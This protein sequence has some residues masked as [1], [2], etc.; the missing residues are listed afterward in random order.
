MYD[1]QKYKEE[2]GTEEQT[3]SSSEKVMDIKNA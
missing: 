2:A 1:K 3:E